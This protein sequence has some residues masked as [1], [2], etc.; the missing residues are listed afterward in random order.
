M[1]GWKLAVLYL[2]TVKTEWVP[3]SWRKV[4]KSWLGSVWSPGSPALVWCYF[5]KVIKIRLHRGSPD[6]INL[7]N[8]GLFCQMWNTR[9]LPAQRHLL[10]NW[11]QSPGCSTG[12]HKCH[13]CHH[14]H[15]R[16]HCHCHHRR[17]RQQLQ[18][19][20]VPH[21]IKHIIVRFTKAKR[22]KP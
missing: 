11:Q 8:Q 4:E 16:H 17:H 20:R 13:H 3:K 1:I 15:R 7:W 12:P 5:R 21:Q 6:W 9:G 18:G 14:C 2:N 22:Y 19:R 10:Q